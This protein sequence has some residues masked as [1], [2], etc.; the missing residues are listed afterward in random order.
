[1]DQVRDTTLSLLPLLAL[2]AA[3][4]LFSAYGKPAPVS[5]LEY[6]NA[7]TPVAGWN[8]TDLLLSD[9]RV[10]PLPGIQKL[11]QSSATLQELIKRGIETQPDGRIVAL[12]RLWHWCGNDP[13]RCDIRRVDLS[14]ALIFLHVAEP[15]API[16]RPELTK[17]PNLALFCDYGWNVSEYFAFTLW[18]SCKDMR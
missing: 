1:L 14:N 16:S 13:I 5:H 11:P 18:S 6:L 17:E 15:L 3:A 2:V 10:L 7:P 4:F 12:A 9:G 8:D